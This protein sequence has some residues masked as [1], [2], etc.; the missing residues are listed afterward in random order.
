MAIVVVPL[1]I[2]DD[3]GLPRYRRLGE[4]LRQLEAENAELNAEARRLSAE[5]QRLRSDPT[6][7][8][9][10]ARDE[11]GMVRDGEIIFQFPAEEQD[12]P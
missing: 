10:V 1:Q 7:L 6:S 4:E 9:H 2:L 11:L 12:E 8:E 5:V 3:R